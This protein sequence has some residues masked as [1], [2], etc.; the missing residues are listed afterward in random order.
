MTEK[1][2]PNLHT[3]PIEIVY[4]ILDKLDNPSVV[5]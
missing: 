1:F 4:R 5:Y 2:V 3:L